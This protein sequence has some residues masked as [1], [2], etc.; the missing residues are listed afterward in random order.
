M[1]LVRLGHM[2]FEAPYRIAQNKEW[3][4]KASLNMHIEMH[5]IRHNNMAKKQYARIVPRY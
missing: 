4:G 5:M 3:L 1:R 2:V